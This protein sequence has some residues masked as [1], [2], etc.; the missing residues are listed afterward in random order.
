[1]FFLNGW[2]FFAK[3]AYQIVSVPDAVMSVSVV[4]PGSRTFNLPYSGLWPLVFV[5][6]LCMMLSYFILL[7]DI[8]HS[9]HRER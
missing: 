7:V 2:W 5:S 4:A 1:M 9:G 8:G 3:N 6:D